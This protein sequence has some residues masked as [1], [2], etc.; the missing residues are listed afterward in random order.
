LTISLFDHFLQGVTVAR[1]RSFVGTDAL[2]KLV[3]LLQ[4]ILLV[5]LNI[6]LQAASGGSPYGSAGDTPSGNSSQAFASVRMKLSQLQAQVNLA[7]N[8]ALSTLNPPS[9][10][11]RLKLQFEEPLIATGPTL[12]KEDAALLES[13]KQYRDR[14]VK[15]DLMSLTAFLSDFPA[16]HWRVAI[17]TNR[18]LLEY[19]YGYF[20]RA[21]ESW[22]EAWHAGRAGA[23]AMAKPLVDGAI[24]ELLRMHAR[25][26]H[27]ERFET[28]FT[29]LGDR[30]LSGPATEALDG[31][32]QGLWM[33]R[34]DPGVAYLCG[35]MALKNLLVFQGTRAPGVQFFND[36]RSGPSGVTL[37]QVADLADRAHLPH[38]LVFRAPGQLVPLPSIVHWKVTHFAAIVGESNGRLHVQDPTF[39]TDLWITR[40]A[41]DSESSGYFL[42]PDSQ[43]DAGWREVTT[44]EAAQVRGMGYTGTN[45]PGSTTP[46]HDK[47]KPGTCPASHGMCDYNFTEMTVSLNLNDTPVGYAPAERTSGL[48]DPNL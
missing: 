20:S 32:K 3:C 2:R 21:I 10:F 27:A 5:R 25:L 28:L 12:P 33:M 41:L 44:S 39:G 4:I 24:G 16:S 31:A 46:Q 30:P 13:P 22:E 36:Y 37:A 43:Q 8:A 47:T 40:Q 19:H 48:C 18:G 17:L 29:E 23:S 1:I 42:V 34:H 14:T 6:P 7:A 15:D 38:R 35:P 45:K 9:E 26:G 11:S